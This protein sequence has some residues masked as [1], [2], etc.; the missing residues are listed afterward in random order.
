MTVSIAVRHTRPVRRRQCR[1]HLVLFPKMFVYLLL[2]CP[3][4]QEVIPLLLRS[5]GVLRR[6]PNILAAW[7]REW[8]PA[9]RAWFPSARLLFERARPAPFPWPWSEFGEGTRAS[10]AVPLSRGKNPAMGVCAPNSAPLN[11]DTG[12][13]V[14]RAPPRYASRRTTGAVTARRPP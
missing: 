3:T 11:H 1:G 5:H 9:L 4:T 6:L 8:E 10:S 12:A 13:C 2:T 14:L 7:Y